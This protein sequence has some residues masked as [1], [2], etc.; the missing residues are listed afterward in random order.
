V[1]GVGIPLT[2]FYGIQYA[3]GWGTMIQRIPPAHLQLPSTPAG[4]VALVSLF[5]TFVLGET[6]VPPYVQ[7]LLIGKTERDVSRGTLFSGLFQF[8]F[9]PLRD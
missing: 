4:I 2:L 8:R 7:R 3:G 9:S 1:L 6:L 5:L